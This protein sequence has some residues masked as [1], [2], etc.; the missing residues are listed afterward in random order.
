MRFVLF[1][2]TVTLCSA[3]IINMPK[4]SWK[5]IGAIDD[6]ELSKF[7]NSCIDYLWK[8]N[9]GEWELYVTKNIDVNYDKFITEIK[10]AEGFWAKSNTD[11]IL[12]ISKSIVDSEEI[13]YA[14]GVSS[15]AYNYEGAE[16][17]VSMYEYEIFSPPMVGG[18]GYSNS[19]KLESTV[20]DND[21]VSLSIDLKSQW[22]FIGNPTSNDINISETTSNFVLWGYENGD[23]NAYS[24]F[25]N[26]FPSYETNDGIMKPGFGYCLGVTENSNLTLNGKR[27]IPILDGHKGWVQTVSSFDEDIIDFVARYPNTNI[28]NIWKYKDGSWKF[29]NTIED[30]IYY[31]LGYEKISDINIGDGLWIYID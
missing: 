28:I 17:D 26:Q 11:C 27:V 23:W 13:T 2:I 14:E 7:N 9:N 8:Y 18:Y 29:Y 22:N 12:D 5:M 30:D 25:S 1:F 6:V 15:E 3:Q 4:D 31:I 21:F 19:L 16:S 20:N 24:D 10:S